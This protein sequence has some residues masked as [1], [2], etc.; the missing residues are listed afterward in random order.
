MAKIGLLYPMYS[1]I[2]TGTRETGEDTE[3]YGAVTVFAKAVTASTSINTAKTK[4]YADDGVAEAI[5]EF[6]S[7]QITFASDDIEDSVKSDI[8]GAEVDAETG[9]ITYSDTDEG[10]YVRFGFLIRRRKTNKTQ[11]KAIV[12]AKVLF[13]IPADDYE[14]KGES[15]VFKSTQITGE[16]MRNVNHVWKQES[17]WKDTESDAMAELKAL[18]KPSAE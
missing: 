3:T 6:I 7:G 9:R 15:V 11:Y 18:L 8:I 12:F 16:L 17:A 2:T 4:F 5:N 14:T 1:K 10:C 13:D